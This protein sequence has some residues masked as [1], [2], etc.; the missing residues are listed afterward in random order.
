MLVKPSETKIGKWM[1]RHFKTGIVLLFLWLIY[2]FVLLPGMLRWGA[3]EAEYRGTLPGDDLLQYQDYK[4]TLAVTIAATPSQ[5]W[6][7]VV[8]MG[9]HKGGFYSYTWLENTFGCKLVN[10][11]RIH[12]EWQHP[13][14]GDIEPVCAS[15]EGKP[16]A[17]WQIAVLQ[18]NRAMVWKGLGGAQWMMGIYIDSVDAHTCR[19]LTRQ[20]F[21]FPKAGSADWLLEKLWFTWAHCIMQHGMITGIK[22]RVEQRLNTYN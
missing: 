13:A 14:V 2:H 6:P 21:Q 10:A 7:W 17:G 4:N 8:Q 11:D 5:I 22:K 15:Q 16:N 18:E 12:P 1:R 3:T 19:L 9:L 20:Q